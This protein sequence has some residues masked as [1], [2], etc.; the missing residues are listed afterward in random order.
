MELL[1]RRIEM[2]KLKCPQTAGISANGATTSGLFDQLLLDDLS[3]LT[4]SFNSTPRTAVI[5]ASLE[6]EL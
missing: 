6:H 1:G 3:P 5:A 4:C 2:V